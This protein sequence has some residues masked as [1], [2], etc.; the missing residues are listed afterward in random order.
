MLNVIDYL[1]SK[2]NILQLK[3]EYNIEVIEDT[4]LPLVLFNY[5]NFTP[6]HLPVAQECRGLILEKNTWN[7]VCKSLNAFFYYGEP[8]AFSTQQDFKW[9]NSRAYIKYDG[10][11]LFV[12]YYNNQW[13]VGSRNH[14]RAQTP[15]ASYATSNHNKTFEQVFKETLKTTYKLSWNA[16]CKKL[17]TNHCYS[18]EVF[19]DDL[20]VGILYDN[21]FIVLLS[22]YDK[23]QHKEL[24]IESVHIGVSPM[25]Y[26]M[27]HS[28]DDALKLLD[29]INGKHE[30]LVVCDS[31][32]RR[33]KMRTSSY[34]ADVIP[35][36]SQQ[37]LSS[38]RDLGDEALHFVEL[39]AP[40]FF[41]L[42]T[43]SSPGDST[44]TS[45]DNSTDNTDDTTGGEFSDT[46]EDTG[47]EFSDT[48]GDGGGEGEG[49]G[50]GEALSLSSG[51]ISVLN[52]IQEMTAHYNEIKDY[53]DAAFN[54]AA[55]QTIWPDAYLS[56]RQGKSLI[57]YIDDASTNEMLQAVKKYQ[58][59]GKSVT[60]W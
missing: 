42:S 47:G 24:D 53:D 36:L 60:S 50:G 9:K 23:S 18:F 34:N 40:D 31:E 22:V 20:R 58:S 12:Y 5:T 4:Q 52:M 3:Q 13:H 8:N 45:T 54:F 37:A 48:G 44:S 51:Q 35:A 21:P 26:T 15:A 19:S 14:P 32:F 16:F 2:N 25:E 39:F 28:L 49:E 10:A 17:N 46:S 27:I 59:Q 7:L 33:M 6:M 1:N 29:S 43:S 55:K 30:G 11:L 56:M 38:V 41:I 57:E